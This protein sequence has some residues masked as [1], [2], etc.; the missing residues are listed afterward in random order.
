MPDT[1]N[2]KEAL[3]RELEALAK[4]RD[5]LQ[6][7]MS[8]A[9]AEVRDELRRLGTSWDLVETEL[10][11]LGEHSKESVKDMGAAARSLIDEL[12][13]GFVRVKEQIKETHQNHKE[14]SDA[15]S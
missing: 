5:E 15:P 6:V 12:K 9:K 4:A 10:K 14:T 11:R 8:L 7:N 3:Q 2:V 1:K 13:H